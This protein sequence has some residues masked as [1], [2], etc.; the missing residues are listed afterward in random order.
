MSNVPII[1]TSLPGPNAQRLIKDDLD[2]TSPSL[3]KEYPLT[4]KRAEGMMIEDE[5]GN[6]FLD[7]M[8]GIAVATTGH[9]HPKVVKAIQIQAENLLHICGT[10]FYYAGY[11]DLCKKL[12]ELA[13]G[14][15]SW[16][17]FLS[18]SGTESN[19]GAIKLAR[20]HTKR[21]YIIAF[22]GA[23]HGRTYGALSLTYSKSVQRKGFE[24][25]LP[26]VHHLPYG[27][28]KKMIQNYLKKKGVNPETIAAIFVEPIQ[29]E[30]GYIVPP[31][32]FLK[33]IRSFCD[34]FN[35]MMVDDEVQSG[36]GRTG[37]YFAIENWDVVP[38]IIT[39]A[40]GLGSGMPIGSIIAKENV[41]TW[42]PGS[43]GSTFG[44]NPVSC[45]AAIA[46]IDLIENG[47]MKNAEITGEY[48]HH[49][50]LKLQ[51]RYRIISDARGI[52][53][54]QAI[55]F[56]DDNKLSPNLAYLFEQS[57][58]KKGLLVL[59]CGKSAIRLAPPLIVEQTDID[60]ALEIIDQVLGEMNL[61]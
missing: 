28:S 16:K 49:R 13:P 9:C 50:L 42:P 38:D 25:F 17:V 32:D 51:K 11:S 22:D 40:K 39:L 21:K 54:M 34:E 36:N 47:L 2:V 5:D 41:M 1:S 48:L 14:G 53:L 31:S 26:G 37:K 6:R 45:A 61:D 15:G 27:S 29:G 55:E 4:V 7:F 44:G 12:Q 59:G 23:F 60:I 35:I 52:G 43:H 19:E 10:D 57:C 20:F 3:I 33:Q 46:T 24:P 18:N 58:F 30:G 56:S 8:A